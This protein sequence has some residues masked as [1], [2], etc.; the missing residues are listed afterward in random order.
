MYIYVYSIYITMVNGLI[1]YL[2]YVTGEPHLVA[3]AKTSDLLDPL[4]VSVQKLTM[5]RSKDKS[6]ARFSHFSTSSTWDLSK[7]AVFDFWKTW[8]K[9]WG[10]GRGKICY[11]YT[12]I[13]KIIY[14]GIYVY[15]YRYMYIYIFKYI[16]IYIH[17]YT[18]IYKYTYFI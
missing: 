16:G 10:G 2:T 11:H 1:N 6:S 5:L 7:T 8:F 15:I 18:Y 12:C 17:I 13:Y 3:M 4:W 9:S 14:I